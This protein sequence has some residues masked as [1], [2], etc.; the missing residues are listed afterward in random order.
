[1]FA[2]KPQLGA[3]QVAQ[4]AEWRLMDI[5]LSEVDLA[6]VLSGLLFS[7]LRF[8]AQVERYSALV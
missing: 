5:S 7:G 8:R 2:Q 4:Q 3:K 1:L 6:A